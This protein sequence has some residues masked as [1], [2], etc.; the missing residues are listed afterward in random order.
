MSLF[1]TRERIS[2]FNLEGLEQNEGPR[3]V[4]TLELPEVLQ[5]IRLGIHTDTIGNLLRTLREVPEASQL[6]FEARNLTPA[7]RATLEQNRQ[8]RF[9]M[10]AR[11]VRAGD[12]SL[13]IALPRSFSPTEDEVKQWSTSPF[14]P[15]TLASELGYEMAYIDISGFLPGDPEDQAKLTGAIGGCNELNIGSDTVD[16]TRL[17]QIATQ[18]REALASLDSLVRLRASN[19]TLLNSSFYQI[20]TNPRDKDMLIFSKKNNINDNKFGIKEFLSNNEKMKKPYTS[21]DTYNF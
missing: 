15:R 20:T 14:T 17:Q 18:I 8:F 1:L 2:C 6:R 9:Y 5:G 12:D 3:Y 19:R 11:L 21:M 16:P 10:S 13:G 4:A 7:Q